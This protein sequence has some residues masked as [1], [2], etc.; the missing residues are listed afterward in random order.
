MK[1]QF[2]KYS[3]IVFITLIL[4]VFYHFR[5]PNGIIGITKTVNWAWGFTNFMFW[6]NLINLVVLFLV[7]YLLTEVLIRVVNYF[8]K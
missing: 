5:F 2:W 6:I 8:S 7:V 4:G 3:V 1:K